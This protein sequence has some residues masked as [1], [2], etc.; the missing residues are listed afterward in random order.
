MAKKYT[1]IEIPSTSNVR[2]AIK[3]TF[4]ICLFQSKGLLA[5]QIFS[6]T[7][8]DSL[9]L[10]SN[11]S[12]YQSFAE[13]KILQ[14]TSLINYGANSTT[15]LLRMLPSVSVGG[16]GTIKLR[17]KPV[18]FF[19]NG[20]QTMLSISQ[21]QAQQIQTITLYTVPGSIADASAIGGVLDIQ[22]RS[23]NSTEKSSIFNLGGEYPFSNTIQLSMPFVK[24]NQRFYFNFGSKIS[25]F[26]REIPSQNSLLTRDYTY[27]AHQN[28]VTKSA[29]SNLMME[30]SKKVNAKTSFDVQCNLL[31][32]IG[33]PFTSN[34]ATIS[35]NQKQETFLAK[36]QQNNNTKSIV[37]GYSMRYKPSDKNQFTFQ[38]E[39]TRG[40]NLFD[41]QAESRQSESKLIKYRVVKNKSACSQFLMRFDFQNN[42]SKQ[43]KRHLGLQSLQQSNRAC[44]MQMEWSTKPGNQSP[45]KTTDESRNLIQ[46]Y[47]LYG[48]IEKER[49]RYKWRLGLRTEWFENEI[50][51]SADITNPNF[52]YPSALNNMANMF[53]PDL[54]ATYLIG[55]YSHLN[56]AFSRRM[57][58]P[59]IEQL[60]P[61]NRFRERTGYIVG[62]PELV[63]EIVNMAELNHVVKGSAFVAHTSLYIK[64]ETSPIL[65]QIEP[66]AKDTS[67]LQHSFANGD[68]ETLIG[69]EQFINYTLGNNLNFTLNYN[70][71]NVELEANGKEEK[72]LAFNSKSIVEYSN[73]PF[74]L[75]FINIFDSKQLTIQGYKKPVFSSD[76]GLK[77]ILR[78]DSSLSFLLYDIFNTKKETYVTDLFGRQQSTVFRPE[79]RRLAV[80]FKYNF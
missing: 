40:D 60:N 75:Q 48:N 57:N 69:L 31:G 34:Y 71:F 63:P 74:S 2:L 52:K 14:P 79:Q 3:I 49:K 61:I 4:V 76:L 28:L 35:N 25:D 15:E 6:G 32:D 66:F 21:I 68:E 45:N 67:L 37:A 73:G 51:Y 17:G 22:L 26:S 29:S 59:T 20:K 77:Y 41:S 11:K 38:S 27:V 10:T 64:L 33:K 24:K 70:L 18:N 47:A 13:R 58:R 53:F 62:N 50:R 43:T 39:I 12:V 65:Q 30:Y 55:Q 36:D 19:V 46:N 1:F 44:S 78:N 42:P 16:D 23:T 5:Q 8:L 80:Q 72:A 54:S 9:L 56:L 7:L